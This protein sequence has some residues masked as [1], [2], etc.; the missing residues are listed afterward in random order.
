MGPPA[1]GGAGGGLLRDGEIARVKSGG[2]FSEEGGSGVLDCVVNGGGG[3][4]GCRR[5]R[6]AAIMATGAV[7]GK[8][9]SLSSKT[10]VASPLPATESA[11][12][13]DISV[14]VGV[15]ARPAIRRN[16]TQQRNTR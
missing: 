12:G 7:T 4:E 2:G 13:V 9:G 6:N 11:V 8:G 1:T 15:L 3:G 14:G 5:V 16:R 10:V